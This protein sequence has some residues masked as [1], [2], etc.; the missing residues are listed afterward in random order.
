M[1]SPFDVDGISLVILTEGGRLSEPVGGLMYLQGVETAM[2]WVV[3]VASLYVGK[4]RLG[5]IE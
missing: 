1:S 5:R 2:C 4:G 3:G